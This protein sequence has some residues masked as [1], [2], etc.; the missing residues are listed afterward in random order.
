MY[1]L[2]KKPIQDFKIYGQ[3]I[4]CG[5]IDFFHLLNYRLWQELYFKNI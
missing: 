5:L 3:N 4:T 2:N 1:N